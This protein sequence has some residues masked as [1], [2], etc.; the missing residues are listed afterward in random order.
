MSPSGARAIEVSVGAGD[1]ALLGHDVDALVTELE[2]L[3]VALD[4]TNQASRSA[5]GTTHPMPPS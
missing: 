3:R 1:T 5:T 2:A 4:E